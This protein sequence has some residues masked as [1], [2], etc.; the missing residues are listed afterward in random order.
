LD[1]TLRSRSLRPLL[2]LLLLSTGAACSDPV[3]ASPVLS[4]IVPEGRAERG[5]PLVLRAVTAAG[6]TLAAGAVAWSAL[7]A[8]AGTWSG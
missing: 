7:P 4:E 3:G 5:L 6:D 2:A 8:D 1:V